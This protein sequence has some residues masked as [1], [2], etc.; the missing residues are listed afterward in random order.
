MCTQ[1]WVRDFG[2]APKNIKSKNLRN[3]VSKPRILFFYDFLLRRS[4]HF[5]AVEPVVVQKTKA[6]SNGFSTA[7]LL[8][9][10]YHLLAVEPVVV[11]RRKHICPASK[12]GF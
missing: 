12:F 1:K 10:S 5:G 7:F 6:H 4:Y 8:Q 11:L 2:S 9:R 3:N